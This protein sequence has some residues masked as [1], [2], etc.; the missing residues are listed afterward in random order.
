MK[1]TDV[2]F[3]VIVLILFAPLF[4][5]TDVYEAYKAFNASH[6]MVIPRMVALGVLLAIASRK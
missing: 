3:A 5:S 4:I 1:K 2:T 6:G